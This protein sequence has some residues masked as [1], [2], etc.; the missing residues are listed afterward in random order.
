MSKAS[1]T[2]RAREL[3]FERAALE[4]KGALDVWRRSKRPMQ[5]VLFTMPGAVGALV[6]FAVMI[7]TKS[8]LVGIFTGLF[9]A[10]LVFLMAAIVLG[11]LVATDAMVSEGRKGYALRKNVRARRALMDATESAG[12]VELATDARDG[13][14]LTPVESGGALT[15]ADDP[16]ER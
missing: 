15:S 9:V 4:R 12:G 3:E 6:G 7:P 5:I 2:K 11:G 16:F 10:F 14:E 13:G 1:A 8:A